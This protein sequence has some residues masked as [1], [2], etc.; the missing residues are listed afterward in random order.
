M[1]IVYVSSFLS[2][3]RTVRRICSK[4]CRCIFNFLYY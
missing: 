3:H 4:Y 1:R 2:V